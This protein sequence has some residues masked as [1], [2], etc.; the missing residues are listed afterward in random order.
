MSCVGD[1]EPC[2]GHGV[3]DLSR[4]CICANDWTGSGCDVP[5]CP[6]DCNGYGIC[7]GTTGVP[8]C[9]CDD[10]HFGV[11]CSYPCQNGTVHNE[12]CV[13][14]KFFSGSPCDQECAGRGKIMINDVEDQTT[15]ECDS[16]WWGE[17]CV[18]YSRHSYK[19]TCPQTSP[20]LRL[21]HI[22]HDF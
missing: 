17:F 12:T 16:A 5:V 21:P 13:C 18:S 9:L 1:G 10:H 19:T 3:C 2:S 8:F 6:N 22:I 15:C 20:D 7:N 11:D 14:E 4:E